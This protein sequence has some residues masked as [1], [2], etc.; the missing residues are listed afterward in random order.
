MRRRASI[1]D[2]LERG[3]GVSIFTLLL[4]GLVAGLEASGTLERLVSRVPRRKRR[5]GENG[6]AHGGHGDR[7][8]CS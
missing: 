3:V 2:G 8:R 7:A 4:M 5:P 6:M 1:I